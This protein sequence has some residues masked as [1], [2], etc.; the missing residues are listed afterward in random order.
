MQSDCILS[1]INM[2]FYKNERG[3]QQLG[4]TLPATLQISKLFSR[5]IGTT[6]QRK[7]FAPKFMQCNTKLQ[8]ALSFFIL[9]QNWY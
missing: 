8:H 3:F 7:I 9:V 4:K 6:F 2:L 5:C 1:G